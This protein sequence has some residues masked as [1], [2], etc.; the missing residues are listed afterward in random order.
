[1]SRGKNEVSPLLGPPWK[2][3]PMPV[4]LCILIEAESDSGFHFKAVT[5]MKISG[6]FSILLGFSHLH[7][8]HTTLHEMI[9]FVETVI[10]IRDKLF[11]L[12]TT[13]LWLC[14]ALQRFYFISSVG[15]SKVYSW[16]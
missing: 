15:S 4:V 2:K 8:F 11:K 6:W 13:V 3:L 10:K 14:F 1:M 5:S 16:G 12:K 7:S 9:K